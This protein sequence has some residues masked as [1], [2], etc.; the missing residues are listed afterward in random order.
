MSQDR[1]RAQGGEQGDAGDEQTWYHIQF[2]RS[3]SQKKCFLQ[4]CLLS[5]SVQVPG[6]GLTEQKLSILLVALK[7][8]EGVHLDKNQPQ[9]LFL[10]D[11]VP[12]G[13]CGSGGCGYITAT[14]SKC[15]SLPLGV[16]LS[17]P[18]DFSC[19]VRR[20]VGLEGNGDISTASCPGLFLCAKGPFPHLEPPQPR[21]SAHSDRLSTGTVHSG[22][23]MP[24]VF[25][26][27]PYFP[28]LGDSQCLCKAILN[29]LSF[30]QDR[31]CVYESGLLRLQLGLSA[32]PRSQTYL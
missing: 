21:D 20:A 26:S 7:Y 12:G 5:E 1:V 30:V 2:C 10:I 3:S 23:L 31:V 25:S 27:V 13:F 11:S 15:P 16:F 6:E 17:S 32:D 8:L 14:L 24:G 9:M 28:D 29:V 22:L 4:W 18:P 19:C